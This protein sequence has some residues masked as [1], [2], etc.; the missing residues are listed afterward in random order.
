[1]MGLGMGVGLLLLL[2][3]WGVLIAGAAWLAKAVFV[4]RNRSADRDAE[5][6]PLQILDQRYARGEIGTEEY[7]QIRQDLGQ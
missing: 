2:L 7:Q 1:M 6:K 4:G 5:L 3:F